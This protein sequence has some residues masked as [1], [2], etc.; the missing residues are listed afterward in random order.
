MLRLPLLCLG[1]M[2]LPG[3]PVYLAFLGA[4]GLLFPVLFLLEGQGAPRAVTAAVLLLGLPCYLLGSFDFRTELMPLPI[5]AA[6][7]LA[8]WHRSKARAAAPAA[9]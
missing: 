8:W 4:Y 1:T 5:A 9:A 7:V 2:L 3:E 6:L